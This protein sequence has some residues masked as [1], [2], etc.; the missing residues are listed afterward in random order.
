M[1]HKN[2]TLIKSKI[3]ELFAYRRLTEL[4]QWIG[5]KNEHA[6]KT[7]LVEL[8]YQ[9][10]LLDD[11]L[12]TTWPLDQSALDGFWK[13][14]RSAFKPFALSENEI[15]RQLKEIRNYQRIE[16]DCRIRLWPTEISFKEFYTTKSCDVRLIRHLLYTTHPS[17]KAFCSEKSW[18]YYDLITEINDDITDVY[19]DLKTY[20]ANR[21]LI[22]I[23]RKGHLRTREEYVRFISKVAYQAETYFKTNHI[24]GENAQLFEWTTERMLETLDLLHATTNTIDHKLFAESWLLEKMK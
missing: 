7:H 8:Q 22:S 5:L 19:E 3:D 23:L 16:S 2:E 11:Y 14:I 9:I 6:I 1:K 4:F 12:E 24:V 13:G 17:L 20:N 15:D 18:V 21:F 10:Y